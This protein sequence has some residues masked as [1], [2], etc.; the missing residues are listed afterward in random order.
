[1][2]PINL[3]SSSCSSSDWYYSPASWGITSQKKEKTF[4]LREKKTVRES[5]MYSILLSRGKT[6]I[7]PNQCMFSYPTSHDLMIFLFKEE[8]ITYQMI[9]TALVWT[10]PILR[11]ENRQ[12]LQETSDTKSNTRFWDCSSLLTPQAVKEPDKWNRPQTT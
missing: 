3:H 5:N 7:W 1:M 8:D 4:T 6:I 11:W 2:S 10:R 12:D 9:P